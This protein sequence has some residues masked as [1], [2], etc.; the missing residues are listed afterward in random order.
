MFFE[1]S[2]NKEMKSNRDVLST[3][4]TKISELVSEIEEIEEKSKENECKKE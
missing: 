3:K 4:K 1:E 2:L